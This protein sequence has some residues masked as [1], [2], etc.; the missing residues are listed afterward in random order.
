MLAVYAIWSLT[1][2]RHEQFIATA[3]LVMGTAGGV[4]SFI[5][6]VA[7][8]H[9]VSEQD[10]IV[11]SI[12]VSRWSTIELGLGISTASL[13][14]LRPLSKKLFGH[15]YSS[16]SDS[17][18]PAPLMRQVMADDEER[19]QP[20]VHPKFTRDSIFLFA[21]GRFKSDDSGLPTISSNFNTL[22]KKDQ[23]ITPIAPLRNIS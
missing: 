8:L 19:T 16:S 14:T 12:L 9:R 2:P 23:S 20:K 18:S 1:L 13:A 22:A 10:S 17:D 7:V 4:I 6:F 11:G 3:L 5:R 15:L 21:L